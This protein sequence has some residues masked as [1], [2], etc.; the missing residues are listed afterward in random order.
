MYEVLETTGYTKWF[1]S[2][3]DRT[4]KARIVARILNLSDGNFGDTKALGGK[5]MN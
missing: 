5:S 2:L 1:A 3:R 4:T